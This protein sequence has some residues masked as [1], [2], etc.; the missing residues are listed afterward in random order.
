MKGAWA[1][2]DFSAECYH[3][4]WDF[5]LR[6]KQTSILFKALLILLSIKAEIIY[7]YKYMASKVL[8]IILKERCDLFVLIQ[9]RIGVLL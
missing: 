1:P 2:E 7:Y 6:N 5:N 9:T 8:L 4:C 3:N